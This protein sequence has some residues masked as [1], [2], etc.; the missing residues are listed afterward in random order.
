M[1][2][3]ALKTVRTLHLGRQMRKMVSK[4]KEKLSRALNQNAYL[5]SQEKQ[6]DPHE[7]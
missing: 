7:E 2:L 4:A 5:G 6:A 3:L 1:L